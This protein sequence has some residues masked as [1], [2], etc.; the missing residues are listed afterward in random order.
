MSLLVMLDT[1]NKFEYARWL[2][3][4]DLDIN[5]FEIAVKSIPI[6]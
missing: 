3:K 5:A 6:T 2:Q 1:K 4:H